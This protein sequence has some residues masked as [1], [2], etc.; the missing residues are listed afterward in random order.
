M[1]GSYSDQKILPTYPSSVA[2]ITAIHAAGI[3]AHSSSAPGI[4]PRSAVA[5][6][7]RRRHRPTTGENSNFPFSNW[8]SPP[9]AFSP[10]LCWPVSGQRYSS[11]IPGSAPWAGHFAPPGWTA[12]SSAWCGTSPRR[13]GS[14]AACP[15]AVDRPSRGSVGPG[16]WSRKFLRPPRRCPTQTRRRP[17][18]SLSSFQ[19]FSSSNPFRHLF[20][21]KSYNKWIF[22]KKKASK[23]DEDIQSINQSTTNPVIKRPTNQ[24]INQSIKHEMKLLI[25]QS[26][27]QSIINSLDTSSSFGESVAARCEPAV[28]VDHNS[29]SCTWSGSG[30][31]VVK[32]SV[33]GANRKPACRTP[34]DAGNAKGTMLG[35]PSP[36][37]SELGRMGEETNWPLGVMCVRKYAP[38]DLG[39]PVHPLEELA[40]AAAAAVSLAANGRSLVAADVDVPGFIAGDL[41]RLT[42][43]DFLS[44][45]VPKLW[46][47]SVS[48]TAGKEDEKSSI[49]QS[50]DRSINQSNEQLRVKN[51]Y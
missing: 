21:N 28:T 44:A 11:P 12:W 36:A 32:V 4:P 41:R 25:N 24:P 6:T 37:S 31:G 48:K 22:F 50:I 15:P 26:I 3:E 45:R 39:T 14:G 7:H 43:G 2:L 47:K 34:G 29:C 35:E 46:R 49:N 8:H 16:A 13:S 20:Q 1:C 38:G 33:G 18:P 42:R 17:W 40:P 19:T 23:K 30:S 9:P 51:Y 27:N 5:P 10:S